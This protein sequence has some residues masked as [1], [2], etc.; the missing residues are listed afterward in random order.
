MNTLPCLGHP[1]P[2]PRAEGVGGCF[3]AVLIT[4]NS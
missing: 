4:L 2:N 3:G 1:H